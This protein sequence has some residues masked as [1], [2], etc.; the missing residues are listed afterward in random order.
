MEVLDVG[1]GV[2]G[3]MGALVRYTE[4]SPRSSD[5]FR[6]VRPFRAGISIT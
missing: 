4:V 3:P 5:H 1:C 6:V 2:G